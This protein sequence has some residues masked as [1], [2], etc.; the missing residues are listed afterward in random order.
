MT[1]SARHKSYIASVICI[2]TGLLASGCGTST[3]DIT[4]RLTVKG[5][6]TKAEGL[7]IS[8]QDT[9][10]KAKT[11]VVAADGT[12]SLT[13]LQVGETKV[14][15]GLPSGT[16]AEDGLEGAGR[17]PRPGESYQAFKQRMSDPIEL[18]KQKAAAERAVKGA[19][20]VPTKYRDPR[21]SGVTATLKPGPNTFDFD[22]R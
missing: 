17:V 3:A 8:F 1:A 12:F 2:V 19:A 21:T 22:I 7:T 15:F 5:Q 18:A 11:T 14:A 13:G 20:L 4:G 6:V 16:D 9:D 10:G